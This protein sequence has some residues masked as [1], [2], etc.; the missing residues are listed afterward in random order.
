MEL[1]QKIKSLLKLK[2]QLELYELSVQRNLER[3]EQDIENFAPDNLTNF[4]KV[5]L[6][7]IELDD[8]VRGTAETV[9]TI[10]LKTRHIL[11][12]FPLDTVALERLETLG[13]NFDIDTGTVVELEKT[14]K[15]IN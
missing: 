1:N 2:A 12:Q 14:K 3:L 10:F 7:N 4:Q 6:E 11:R 9:E 8:L 13:V 15:E 5:T